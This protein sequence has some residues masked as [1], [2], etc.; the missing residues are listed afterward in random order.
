[1]PLATANGI[2]GVLSAHRAQA[3]CPRFSTQLIEKTENLPYPFVFQSIKRI[4]TL[5]LFPNQINSKTKSLHLH[6][7]FQ[8][9]SQ[10]IK[11]TPNFA[12]S[13]NP[14][15]SIKKGWQKNKILQPSISARP[16]SGALP[17]APGA[18]NTSPV[19]PYKARI[20]AMLPC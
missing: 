15:I 11:N 1:M 16:I 8:P 5:H 17:L 14:T 19:S 18:T 20:P 4:S 10:K 13:F 6:L 2:C 3:P 7:F 9:N 12:P